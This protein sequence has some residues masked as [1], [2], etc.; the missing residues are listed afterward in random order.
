MLPLSAIDHFNFI[1]P[2]NYAVSD[3]DK[4]QRNDSRSNQM[5]ACSNKSLKLSTAEGMGTNLNIT[6]VLP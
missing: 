1:K 5:V 2:C 3:G 6:N 4:I